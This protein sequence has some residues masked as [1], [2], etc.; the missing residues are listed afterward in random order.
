MRK[1]KNKAAN[2]EGGGE[3]TL[4]RLGH[5]TGGAENGDRASEPHI[6]TE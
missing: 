1:N 3:Q 5:R 4:R 6:A 2:Q